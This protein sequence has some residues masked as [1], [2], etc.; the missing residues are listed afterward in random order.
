VP[1]AIPTHGLSPARAMKQ[2]TQKLM[3][4]RMHVLD[5]PAPIA[6]RGTL[7]VRNAFSVIS[8]G[9]EGSKVKAARKSL[10]GKARERPQQARQMI[11]LLR[12]A[13]PVQAYRTAMKKL[14]SYSPLG[15]SCAGTVIG[16]GAGVSGFRVG[17]K[18]ACAGMGAAHA[19]IV[20]VPQNLCAPLHP[21]ADLAAA[22]YNTLG[23]I[24]LQGVRQADLRLGETCGVI[25]L[26]LLGQITCL[27]LRAAGNKVVGIDIDPRVVDL[28]AQHAADLAAR[29]GEPGLAERIRRFT[30]GIGLD[31]VIITAAS[32]S[33]DPV[34]FAG[35][36][37]RRRGRVVIVGSVP[38]GF[39]REPHFYQKELDLRMSCSYG[40]GRYDPVY[41]EKGIDYPPEYVR[42]S[43]RRNMEIFQELLHS[44]AI[45]VGHLTTHTFSLDEAPKAYDLI[46]GKTEFHLGIVIRYDAGTTSANAIT[47][48]ATAAEPPSHR[49]GIAFVGAGSYALSHLLPNLPADKW[50]D[51]VAVMTASGLSGRSVAE[52]FGFASCTSD[53]AEIFGNPAINAVFVAT[54][55]D[56]HAGY[57]LEALAA[58]KHVF[59]E[60]PLCLEEE[61][62]EAI[63]RAKAARPHT[64][65]CVGFNRRFSPL[66]TTM[67]SALGGGP[68]AML[69]RVNAGALPPGSWILDP[70]VGG[71]RIIG[72]ACHFVDLMTFLNGS[73]PETVQAFGLEHG[74]EAQTVTINL[75]FANGSVGSIAY[76]S[77]GPKELPKEYLEIYRDGA[78]AILR[79]FKEAEI[80]AP[81]NA[82]RSKLLFQDKGPA[83]LVRAFLEAVKDGTPE[84]V[85]FDE[86]VAVTRATFRI[87]E[88]LATSS[89]LPVE[90]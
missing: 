8:T 82:H 73:L 13:G 18:V 30:G 75:R 40:P 47:L 53:P 7:L 58:G 1:R 46:T 15:Y 29:R 86:I 6:S 26:G 23:A 84:P 62:L 69:Y 17:D 34:N 2:L 76:F 78:A 21:D 24:A 3:D 63:V 37:L 51:R 31:A 33:T 36:I 11:D 72:E 42:W 80:V 67:R 20:A 43:E 44:R 14:S 12:R 38:T 68:M 19:E 22:S 49:A 25:G 90:R 71:G 10:V 79:D 5:V 57:V 52:R 55:H 85:P 27:L 81:G 28:A 32:A 39:D 64:K 16:V 45:D 66:V 89:V 35:E 48:H 65:L 60:K 56:T 70:E 59:V 9:T 50:L 61:Q 83:P 54:R 41:E 4:G 77:N 88:S 74:A 87:L